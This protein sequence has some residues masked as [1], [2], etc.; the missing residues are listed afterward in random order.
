MEQIILLSSC[1]EGEALMSSGNDLLN[2]LVAI[3]LDTTVGVVSLE[4]L[5]LYFLPSLVLMLYQ[6]LHK[7]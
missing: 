7:G 5:E 3:I 4:V 1:N 6:L 2:F